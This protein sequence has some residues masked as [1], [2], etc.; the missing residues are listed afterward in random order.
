MRTPNLMPPYSQAERE[1]RA[2][3]LVNRLAAAFASASPACRLSLAKLHQQAMDRYRRLVESDGP[4]NDPPPPPAAPAARPPR[5]DGR[6]NGLHLNPRYGQWDVI[7]GG[8]RIAASVGRL[9]AEALYDRA[10]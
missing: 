7:V 3:R 10:A 4:E 6:P 2:L 8:R 5:K 1:E 9:D